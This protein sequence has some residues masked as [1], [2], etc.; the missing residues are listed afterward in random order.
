MNDSVLALC[1]AKKCRDGDNYI[2][3]IGYRLRNGPKLEIPD[4]AYDKHTRR[5]KKMGRGWE[6][7]LKE[8]AKVEP[9]HGDKEMEKRAAECFKWFERTRVPYYQPSWKDKVK[10]QN[11]TIDEYM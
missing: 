5:G 4:Y 8:G 10:T 6:H 11:N 9:D 1:R 2:G 7:F 3:I